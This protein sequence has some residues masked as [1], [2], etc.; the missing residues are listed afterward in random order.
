MIVADPYYNNFLMFN[1]WSFILVF[2]VIGHKDKFSFTSLLEWEVPKKLAEH[3]IFKYEEIVLA[4][5]G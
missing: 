4:N 2:L 1:F 5:S 3:I